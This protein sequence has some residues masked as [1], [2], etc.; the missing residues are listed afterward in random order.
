M[1]RTGE[2]EPPAVTEESR[3]RSLVNDFAAAV[4]REDQSTILNL[5]CTAEVEEFMGDDDFDP[6]SEPLADPPS[7]RP[8]T[9]A[10]VRISADIASA[11]VTRPAQPTVTL[12]F[13]RKEDGTWKVCAPAGD[14][15][16]P[17]ASASPPN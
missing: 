14:G 7:V 11:Q 15:T 16:E 13:L 12:H 5:L 2:P 8:V 3:I 9:I 1:T 10:D 6:S 17:S 4:D